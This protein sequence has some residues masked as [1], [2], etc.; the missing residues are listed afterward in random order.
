MCTESQS[1]QVADIAAKEKYSLDDLDLEGI[2]D[3]LNEGLITSEQL[4]N[5]IFAACRIH[6]LLIDFL[7]LHCKD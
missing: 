2:I 7:D 5:V 6:W 3:G 4:V 1:P